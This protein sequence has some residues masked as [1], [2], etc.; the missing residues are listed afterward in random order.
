[1]T[2]VHVAGQHLRIAGADRVD[3]VLVVRVLSGGETRRPFVGLGQVGARTLFVL[4]PEVRL[5]LLAGLLDPEPALRA[6]EEVAD[7][8]APFVVGEAAARAEFERTAVGVLEEAGLIVGC[9]LRRLLA[10]IPA[11]RSNLDRV[12]LLL[13]PPTRDVELMRSLVAAVAVAVV[14]VPVP[15]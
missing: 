5:P 13:Q 4:R 8:H 10:G 3:E 7:L 9:F 15:V 6:V 12:L 1:M 14:P 11:D 2:L